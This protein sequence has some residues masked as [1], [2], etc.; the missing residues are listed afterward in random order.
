MNGGSIMFH[1]IYI[2]TN[3]VN[4][5]QY[6]GKHSTPD[7]Y[8]DYIGSGKILKNAIRYHGREQ[9]T[10]QVLHI[11]DNIDDMNKK[12]KE[13]ITEEIINNSSYYNVAPGGE[14]GDVLAYA[15]AQKQKN[16]SLAISARLKGKKL[17]DWHRQRIRETH[18]DIS[19]EKNP[20]FGKTQSESTR[21]LISQRRLNAPKMMCKCGKEVDKANFK[22][23]HG[24]NCRS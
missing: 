16:K 4:G 21:E 13:L 11:F 14:G 22:R 17:S 20:M 18:A 3:N 5:K 10:K 1:T 15:D 23:W 19:G 8:D 7:P 12:E 2:T 24:D 6:I 9:F